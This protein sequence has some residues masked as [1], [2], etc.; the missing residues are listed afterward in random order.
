MQEPDK[1]QEIQKMK[2]FTEETSFDLSSRNYD[3][4]PLGQNIEKKEA[5]AVHTKLHEISLA[6]LGE[7][8]KMPLENLQAELGML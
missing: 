5:L 3:P 2:E 4:L 7:V 6:H 1:Y 8:K